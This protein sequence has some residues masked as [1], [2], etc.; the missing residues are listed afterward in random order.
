M[1][2]G[3]V[4]R[5]VRQRPHHRPLFTPR[6][7]HRQMFANLK[8]WRLRADRLE[9]ATDVERA[10]GL[11]IEALVLR[12]APRQKDVDHRLRRPH[13]AL[14]RR[15]GRGPRGGERIE[16]EPEHAEGPGLNGRP[17]AHA[18]SQWMVVAVCHRR[19]LSLSS[20]Q[21]QAASIPRRSQDKNRSAAPD[22]R[23]RPALP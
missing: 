9:G 22:C 8:P 19:R 10:V 15:R 7:E 5:L 2:G 23:R 18:T 3:V 17:A 11:G 20:K 14:G 12:E 16:G 4:I 6:G 21:A 13:R 1:T